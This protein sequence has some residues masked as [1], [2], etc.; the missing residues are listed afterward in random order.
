VIGYRGLVVVLDE[1]VNLYRITHTVSRNNNYE[2]LLTILNDTLQGR[3][4]HLQILLA[5]TPRFLEDSRRGLFSYEALATRLQGSRFA[6]DGLR[7]LTGPVLNLQALSSEE[8]FLLL[9]R[10]RDLH[11]QHHRYMTT[12]KDE[13]MV[14]FMEEVLNQLGADEF[15]TPRDVIRD[16]VGIL[17]L[18]HQNE[19]MTFRDVFG[20]DA[21]TATAS[22]TAGEMRREDEVSEEFTDFEL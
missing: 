16:F 2:K 17:N 22:D 11:A 13:D 10:I 18:F 21:F 15:L 6:R 20:S 8:I 19:G 7:D 14:A 12:V 9:G 1:A 5:G 3:A 4:A